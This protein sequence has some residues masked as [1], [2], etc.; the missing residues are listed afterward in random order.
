MLSG[1]T[2]S[3]AS[4]TTLD[5]DALSDD[6][7]IDMLLGEADDAPSPHAKPKTLD[8]QFFRGFLVT[9]HRLAIEAHARVDSGAGTIGHLILHLMTDDRPPTNVQEVADAL[10]GSRQA[11][12]QALLQ[13]ER[14]ELVRRTRYADGPA[15]HLEPTTA[16]L[17][18]WEALNTPLRAVL[19]R[20]LGTLDDEKKKDLIETFEQIASSLAELRAERRWG[21]GGKSHDAA[22]APVASED[23]TRRTW[24]HVR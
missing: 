24:V 12:S 23:P 16:V 6:A 21:D 15:T 10:G 1:S 13:L 9:A 8:E 2:A 22:L 5:V 17:E 14:R 4:D 20:V 18:N 7:L 3:T 11:A 19:E